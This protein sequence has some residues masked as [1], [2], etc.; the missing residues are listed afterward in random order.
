MFLKTS[1]NQGTGNIKS[2]GQSGNTVQ[3]KGLL[4]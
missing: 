2:Q 3:D 1:G 4:L